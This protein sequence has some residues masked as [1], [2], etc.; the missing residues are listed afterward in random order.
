[1]DIGNKMIN[2]TLCD[3]AEFTRNLEVLY[4][5]LH[6]KHSMLNES[7]SKSCVDASKNIS[8]DTNMKSVMLFNDGIDQMEVGENDDA[9][10]FFEQAL[11]LKP[12]FA[13]A[14][15]NIGIIKMQLS[16][17]EEAK[18]AFEMAIFVD[19]CLAEAHYNFG[20]ILA[21]EGSYQ[22]A[23]ESF[24]KAIS[25]NSEYGNAFLEK[26]NA[27][28][29]LSEP[30]RALECYENAAGL[31]PDSSVI[32]NNIGIAYQ[33]LD[34]NNEAELY[35]LEALFYDPEYVPP[36]INLSTHF[37]EI[38]RVT[39]AERI[40][41][42]GLGYFPDDASLLAIHARALTAQSKIPAALENLRRAVTFNSQDAALR[43]SLIYSLQYVNDP[44]HSIISIEQKKWVEIHANS[45]SLSKNFPNVMIPSRKLI[46]GYLSPDFCRHPVGYFIL[47]IIQNHNRESFSV[48]CYSDAK[49][50]DV[51]TL[52]LESN[53]DK[54]HDTSRCSN[55]ELLDLI[56][57]DQVDIL[58]DLAGHT[59]GNRLTLFAARAA[60]IQISW[61]GYPNTTGI[62]AIDFR[63]SDAIADPETINKLGQCE[64]L[65]RLPNG[66]HCY[67][68]PENAPDVGL[69]PSISK[70]NITFG[71]FNN[72]A[73]ISIEVIDLWSR[74]LLAVPGSELLLKHKSFIDSQ[75]TDSFKMAF[76]VRGVAGERV[77][78]V[79]AIKSFT[80]HLELYR[81]IDIAL[82]PFPYNGTM[83]TFETLYMGVPVISLRGDCHAGRVGASI[84]HHLG[85]E[86]LLEDS[87]EG[88]LNIAVTLCSNIKLLSDYHANLRNRLLG[89]PF[90]DAQL[91]VKVLEN[92]Y[93]D[94]WH[95]YI[96]GF[97]I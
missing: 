97:S 39:D 95:K 26:G 23:I 11:S 65:I 22:K 81:Q 62:S 70:G 15:N 21:K 42:A 5:Q 61:L 40:A 69:P 80:E 79:P 32:S 91:F 18:K 96:E 19:S 1:M 9:V 89:S 8:V 57:F 37:L 56:S 44:S 25:L 85:L 76:V 87:L 34:E 17:I 73:K 58:V 59:V 54:W 77:R 74:L 50:A 63:I 43:S 75:F 30:Y 53:A 7:A 10:R 29:A 86:E 47:P 2:S 52:M 92:A 72:I 38:G 84:L 60:P 27:L 49:K 3:G 12:D 64:R 14:Y 78:C 13:M 55:K 36:Y 20:L 67:Q 16:K 31:I 24:D 51:Q 46:I 41:S 94:V 6:K 90:V 66:F 93:R 68:P 71:C 48:I 4:R 28:L 88:Y 83:T 35:F 45:E 82:D 33:Q